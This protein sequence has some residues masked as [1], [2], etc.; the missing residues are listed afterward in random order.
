MAG[1]GRALWMEPA[2]ETEAPL[3]LRQT[4]HAENDSSSFQTFNTPLERDSFASRLDAAFPAS[5]WGL[6]YARRHQ[7]DDLLRASLGSRGPGQNAQ[8]AA[9]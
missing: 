2:R 9:V 3:S 5:T 1:A 4:P 8:E 6:A 7:G